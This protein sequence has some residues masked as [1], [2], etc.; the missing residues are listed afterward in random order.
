MSRLL[1]AQNDDEDLVSDGRYAAKHRKAAEYRYFKLYHA[2]YRGYRLCAARDC[3]RVSCKKPSLNCKQKIKIIIIRIQQQK[4]AQI[5][6]N[7]N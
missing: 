6:L 4:G 5:M 3:S 1:G 7:F 2:L